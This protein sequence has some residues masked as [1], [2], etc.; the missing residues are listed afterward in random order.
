[1]VDFRSTQANIKVI[2]RGCD[3]GVGGTVKR[4]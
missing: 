4:K 3:L 2:C 1:M